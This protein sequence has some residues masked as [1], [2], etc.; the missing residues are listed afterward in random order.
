MANL[1]TQTETATREKWKEF[2]AQLT[3][4]QRGAR[5]KREVMV[6]GGG[7]LLM[8]DHG[9]PEGITADCPEVL[10]AGGPR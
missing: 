8:T 10:S 4:E 9:P 5:T 2:F 1:Q 7:D 6:D 3:R